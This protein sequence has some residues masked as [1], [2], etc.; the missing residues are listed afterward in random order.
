MIH[1]AVQDLSNR[2]NNLLFPTVS[3]LLY[4]YKFIS[5]ICSLFKCNID[6]SFAKHHY[7]VKLH[8]VI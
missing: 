6:E 4:S 7:S 1:I 2:A 8:S 5:S 3:M